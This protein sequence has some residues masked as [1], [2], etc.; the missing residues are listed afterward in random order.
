RGGNKISDLPPL[1][2]I[3]TQ[4]WRR[5]VPPLLGFMSEANLLFI[6]QVLEGFFG[7][8][9]IVIFSGASDNM[10]KQIAR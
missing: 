3:K 2:Q 7:C 9:K 10:I 5:F 6:Q 1:Q 8:D 4:K